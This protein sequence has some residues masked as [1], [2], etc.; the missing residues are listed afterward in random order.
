MYIHFT[1]DISIVRFLASDPEVRVMIVE[2][3]KILPF[4]ILASS[5]LLEY[6]RSAAVA[7]ASFSLHETNKAKMVRFF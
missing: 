6:R 5:P 4:T 1:F 7:F 2:D 3:N